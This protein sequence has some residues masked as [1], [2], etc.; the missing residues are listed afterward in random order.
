MGS[1]YTVCGDWNFDG[2]GGRHCGIF[3]RVGEHDDTGDTCSLHCKQYT[4]TAHDEQYWLIMYL[5]VL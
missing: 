5:T 1:N 4:S 3:G 2:Y